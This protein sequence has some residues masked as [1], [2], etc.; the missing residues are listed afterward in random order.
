[1]KCFEC[2][3]VLY[4]SFCDCLSKYN[5]VY[6]NKSKYNDLLYFSYFFVQDNINYSFD[7]NVDKNKVF[8]ELSSND[9]DNHYEFLFRD[10][11]LYFEYDSIR[12]LSIKLNN[13]CIKYLDNLI[14]R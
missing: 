3:K 8:C 4:R 2:D 14:F 11:N 1:M 7:F 9:Y 12:D 5:I 13:F 6:I 10:H